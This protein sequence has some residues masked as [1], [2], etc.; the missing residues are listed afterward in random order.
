MHQPFLLEASTAMN[1]NIPLLYR[2]SLE[3]RGNQKKVNNHLHHAI[4]LLTQYRGS[5]MVLNIQ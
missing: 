4:C 3:H 5:G 1:H 2:T